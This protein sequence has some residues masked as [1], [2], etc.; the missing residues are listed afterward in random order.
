V[1]KLVNSVPKYRK[2]RAS[3]QA[4]VTLSGV[5]HYLGPHGTKAS[6]EFYDR[7]IAEWLQNGR[8][9]Q[10]GVDDGITLVE[11]CAKYLQFA[12]GYYQKNGE[13][14]KV[15]PAIKAALKYVLAGRAEEPAASFGPLALKTIQ[16]QIVA[17]GKSRRYA[18]DHLGRIKRM[19]KWGVS[20][21]L[22]P[23][24]VYQSLATVSQLRR[25]KTIARETQPVMPIDEAVVTQTLPH[26]PPIVADM[27]Q[28]ELLTG[29][30]PAELCILRPADIDR[31][32]EVWVYR[33]AAHKTE[34]HG[35]DRVV[36]LGP[37]AQAILNNYL[38]RPAE[39][40]CFCPAESEVLRRNKQHAARKTPLSCGNRPGTNRRSAP[41]RNA[42]D[43]YKVAS[44]PRS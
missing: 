22:I 27:V 38:D 20:E 33:P 4:I 26:L 40:Y 6:K 29:M 43:R 30:R 16:S 31:S 23:P 13:C 18:N 42:G 39:T 34:H 37:Q 41:K 28:L 9:S 1:P 24:E 21:Q 17:A 25:G 32:G 19:F 10:L 44:Y 15:T 2:H 12:K 3:G 35:R 5:D 7:L 36:P 11:L 8:Q 14:T